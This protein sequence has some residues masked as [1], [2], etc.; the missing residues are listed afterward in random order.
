M[1]P[2]RDRT[3]F[4]PCIGLISQEDYFKE[5]QNAELLLDGK[6]E[7]LIN[8]F[9]LSMDKFSKIKIT[10]KLQYTEIEFLP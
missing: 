6:S 2:V 3:M 5:V 9:Y 10:K 4:C 7:D 1:S 8:N